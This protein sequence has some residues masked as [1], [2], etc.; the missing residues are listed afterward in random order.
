MNGFDSGL[1]RIL[2]LFTVG[3]IL[4]AQYAGASGL[5][6][7]LYGN[8]IGSANCQPIVGAVVSSPYNNYATNITNKI[9]N[10]T[11]VLGTGNWSVTVSAQGYKNG[12]YLTSYVTTGAVQQDF[13]LM[14]SN[15][16]GSSC[17]L[18]PGQVIVN[19]TNTTITPGVNPNLTK[20]AS[21]TTLVVTPQQSIV[22]G[23][24]GLI[25]AVVIVVIIAIIVAY[26]GMKK[27]GKSADEGK[28]KK[29]GA[30]KKDEE[31]KQ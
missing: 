10:Y 28:D 24:E 30:K 5:G 19:N 13:V 29:D 22:G 17:G 3:I 21:T 6:W 26:L 18:G 20:N 12:S 2:V 1:Q 23:N 9:G 4:A 15:G 16:L 8:V 25:I 31:E 14:P 7:V 11:L 27:M